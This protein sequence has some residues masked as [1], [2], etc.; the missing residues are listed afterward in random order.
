MFRMWATLD[1][2]TPLAEIPNHARRAEAM[3]FD[4]VMAP[5]VMSDGFLVAQAAIGATEHIRVAT[6]ALVCFPRSPMTT[7]VAAWN[8]QAL[9]GGRFHLGLGPLV[10][11]NIIGKYSTPWTPPAPRMR[12]YVQSLR[13]LFD[14]WQNGTPLDYRG[15]HYQFTRMQDF[16]KPPPI[17]HPEIPIHLAGIGPN[18]TALS[19]ELADALVAHPTNTSPRFLREV[20]RPRMAVGSKRTG[21]DPGDTVLIA[22]PM[23]ATGRDAKTVARERERHRELMAILLS[24]PSYW[25][26][27]D[28][29]GW[30]K[31]GETLH[32]RVRENRW[33]EL[34][35]LLTD[36]MVEV[37]IPCAT[38]DEL[39]ARLHDWYDGV[40]DALTLSIPED[41][42]DDDAI[43]R[44]VAELRGR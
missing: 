41:P 14:C 40:A 44:V 21:R 27:L 29:Y 22:N 17:E 9:S 10:R 18:M 1:L 19:G 34:T 8:L 32:S 26:S 13:A 4:G 7:G 35:P 36:E 43:A 5:D 2:K 16:V 3:G 24:T 38:H 37:L 12:E 31:C 20:A 30:R 39:G 28:L 33:S 6:S 15:E 23:V 25:P 11:G 42:A